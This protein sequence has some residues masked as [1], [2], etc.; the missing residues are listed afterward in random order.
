MWQLASK[1]CVH[2]V[3]YCTLQTRDSQPQDVD[4][5]SVGTAGFNGTLTSS[6]TLATSI[7]VAESYPTLRVT[8]A[9]PVDTLI[10]CTADPDTQGCACG[11]GYCSSGSTNF[12]DLLGAI[13]QAGA[14][15]ANVA[16][17]G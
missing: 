5:S 8:N 1:C 6:Q 14:N 15:A 4:I 17:S 2:C 10:C 3:P 13:L 12:G 11:G 16:N 9:C 7:D